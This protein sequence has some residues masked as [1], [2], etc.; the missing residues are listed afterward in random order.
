MVRAE[1]INPV[2]AHPEKLLVSIMDNVNRDLVVISKSIALAS[3]ATIQ[4][5]INCLHKILHDTESTLNF[6][7]A[8]EVIDVNRGK[9][10]TKSLLV[11]QAI[12][13]RGNKPFVFINC[14]N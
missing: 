1:K 3:E 8:N 2:C 9:I 5:E 11:L 13:L 4:Y 6:C 14:K 10:I 7:K 12:Q